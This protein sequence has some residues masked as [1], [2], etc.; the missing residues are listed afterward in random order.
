MRHRTTRLT[1]ATLGA[2]ALTLGLAAC[3]DDDDGGTTAATT[4]A[5]PTGSSAAAD[6][7]AF[8]TA[9]LKNPDGAEAGTVTFAEDGERVTV[10]V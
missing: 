3:A 7:E 8:A 6:D 4:D 9:T 10:T 5:S 2:A 1:A